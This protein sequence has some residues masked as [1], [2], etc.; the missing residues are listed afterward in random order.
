MASSFLLCYFK[1]LLVLAGVDIVF[2]YLKMILD[3][4]Q[5]QC[6]L[7]GAVLLYFLIVG[8][9]IKGGMGAAITTWKKRHEELDVDLDKNDLLH[10]IRE[11]W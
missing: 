7:Y 3:T 6:A 9:T 11:L 10:K 4:T 1:F 8:G 2:S 5:H